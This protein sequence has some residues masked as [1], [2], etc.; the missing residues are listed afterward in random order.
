PHYQSEV[1]LLAQPVQDA[2]APGDRGHVGPG[3]GDG[4]LAVD[5][6][7]GAEIERPP[8]IG[9]PREDGAGKAE[10]H[11]GTEL[12]GEAGLI[13]SERSILLDRF[14]FEIDPAPVLG[15]PEVVEVERGNA[16][17]REAEREA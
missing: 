8:P 17:V 15:A 3:L 14:L 1:D 7:V 4:A 6:V 5:S 13:R 2:Q 10:R 16:L 11:R 9:A 12:P